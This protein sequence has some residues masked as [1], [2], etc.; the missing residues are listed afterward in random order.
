M[1]KPQSGLTQWFKEKWVDLS[2][3]K[4]GGGFEPCGRDDAKSGKY[5][6]CVPAARAARMTPQ[7]IESA[8]RRKR[9]AESRE[10]REDKKPIMV[11]TVKK[12]ESV[13]TDP[14]LYAK[15]KA[16]AKAKFDV[17]PS[18]Y[19][20]GWLVRE[21]KRRGGKYKVAKYNPNHDS[22]GRFSSSGGAKTVVASPKLSKD[23]AKQ[24][25]V[26]AEEGGFTYDP[27]R[28]QMRRS[29]VA[30]AVAKKHEEIHEMSDFKRDGAKII[31]RYIRTHSEVLSEPNAHLGAW[32][33]KGKVYLDVSIVK[34]SLDE[35]ANLGRKNDQ[36]GIFDLNNF[37][38]WSRAKTSS[39]EYRYYPTSSPT[40]SNLGLVNT[41]SGLVN[42]SVG[43]EDRAKGVALVPALSLLDRSSIDEFVRLIL[44][45]EPISKDEP[46][47][48]DVHVDAPLGRVQVIRNVK[49]KKKKADKYLSKKEPLKDPKGGLTAAGRAK[50]N[51][52]TGSNLKPGVRGKADTPEKMRR[53]GSFLTRFFT[54]PSGP[55][56]KPN[57]EP[58]RL[59]LSA[60]AWGEPVP[61]NRSDAAKLAAKGRRLLE[62]YDNAKN[63]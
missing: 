17:Y 58:T 54:N 4:E 15:V 51:R 8:I 62:R 16:E 19:A 29:G 14:E 24:L 36:I 56:V 34:K 2:R 13:P 48:S 5:P 37:Q 52:E 10:N 55:M 23:T 31:D 40:R 9:T 61:K 49:S 32:V 38:T 39:G 43:K 12:S 7:Q 18:A 57:G 50:Y 35:A 47:S 20:N 45:M 42:E 28:K 21:Y 63:D 26:M 41:G 22:K 3:P 53:K 60:A 30:V 44:T 6:K 33:D 1:T 59:A 11:P 25:K 27:K 46:T